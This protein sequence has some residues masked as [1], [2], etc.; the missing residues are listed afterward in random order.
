MLLWPYCEILP[1][2]TASHFL[3]HV[4]YP[5]QKTII[6]LDSSKGERTDPSRELILRVIAVAL[7]LE[8]TDDWTSYLVNSP[9]QRSE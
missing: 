7:E 3:L 9:Q 1:S 4:V 2:E 8:S 6:T 5:K